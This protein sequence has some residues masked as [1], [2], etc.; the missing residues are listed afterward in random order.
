[1]KGNLVLLAESTTQSASFWASNDAVSCPKF[2]NLIEPGACCDSAG[3]AGVAGMATRASG[4]LG[5]GKFCAAATDCSKTPAG[6]RVSN[7]H[8]LSIRPSLRA[9]L[10][11]MSTVFC[12]RGLR[13]VMFLCA[14]KY[15]QG[16]ANR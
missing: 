3:A 15:V 14:K 12:F 13:I 7:M 16:K 8:C 11:N 6:I 1:M 2:A 4:A 5:A 9:L 10:A